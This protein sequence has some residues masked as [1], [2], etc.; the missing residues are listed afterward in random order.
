MLAYVF[1]HWPRPE[2]DGADYRARL[3]RFHRSLAGSAPAGYRG[4][5][6]FSLASAPWAATGRGVSGAVLEDWYFID[7]FT[8]LGV[9]NEAAVSAA[10]RAVHDEAAA[11]AAG[12]AAG[13]YKLCTVRAAAPAIA[14]R[15]GKPPELSY[16]GLFERIPPGVELWQRQMTL[17]PDPEFCALAARE[18]DFGDLPG[19]RVAV[20]TVPLD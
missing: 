4:S 6:V 17:G 15:F 12:G 10:H 8:A 13:V 1:W 2:T 19:A 18:D 3:G 7:D 11:H 5:R 20:A 9:L 16:P 14:V